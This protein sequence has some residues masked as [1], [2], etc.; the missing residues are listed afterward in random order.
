MMLKIDLK[1]STSRINISSLLSYKQNRAQ[2]AD[3]VMSDIAINTVLLLSVSSTKNLIEILSH[4]HTI[5]EIIHS[6]TKQPEQ[7]KI[8][9]INITINLIYLVITDLQHLQEVNYAKKMGVSV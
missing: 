9:H 1:H 3:Q 6:F 2:V 4:P 7:N 8:E 5:T